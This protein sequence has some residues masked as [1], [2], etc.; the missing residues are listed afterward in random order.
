M[1]DLKRWKS[2]EEYWKAQIER[3]KGR[4]HFSWVR[5]A[6]WPIITAALI[7]YLPQNRKGLKGICH[8]VRSGTEVEEITKALNL[9]QGDVIGTEIAGDPE[10]RFYIYCHDFHEPRIEWQE[11]FSFVYSNSLDHAHDP[12]VALKTWKD[13]LCPGGIMV[14]HWSEGHV[15]TNG[16]D[17]FGATRSEYLFLLK[18]VGLR[19]VKNIRTM[20]TINQRQILITRKM[21]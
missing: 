5:N 19:R 9:K 2:K 8:G 14:I 4:R 12:K 6:E 15:S 21:K 7:R 16:A 18:R 11:A 3:N 13:Q 17:C 1:M 20:P 10:N